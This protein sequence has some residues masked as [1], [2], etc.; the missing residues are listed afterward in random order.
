[1]AILGII[2]TG[3]GG[4]ITAV[5][6]QQEKNKWTMEEKEQIMNELSKLCV[7]IGI[8][9]SNCDGVFSPSE[10]EFLEYYVQNVDSNLEPTFDAKILIENEIINHSSFDEVINATN[11]FLSR[12]D[13][14]ER[15]QSEELWRFLST[16]S[17]KWMVRFILMRRSFSKCGRKRLSD[18]CFECFWYVL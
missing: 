4:I 14:N 5:A 15:L 13:E 2:L 1:M 18:D 9:F 3:L 11:E 17:S 10:R 16:K 8:F 12:F 6:A 7:K